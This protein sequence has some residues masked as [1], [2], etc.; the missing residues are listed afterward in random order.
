MAQFLKRKRTLCL[1]F[2]PNI[3]RSPWNTHENFREYSLHLCVICSLSGPPL[4]KQSW[5]F[6]ATPH[7]RNSYLSFLFWTCCGIMEAKSFLN[8]YY[9]TPGRTGKFIPPQRHKARG[10]GGGRWWWNPSL[11]FW[12]V[13]FSGKPLIFS[14]RWGI[15][16]GWWRYWRPVTSP[17]MSS[18][19]D[20]TKN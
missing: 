7:F 4:L 17:T 10:G 6:P 1:Y 16:S 14:T 18:I 8:Y 3:F 19:L 5:H 9:L 15:F 12:Y 2:F 13:A 11:E 20:F